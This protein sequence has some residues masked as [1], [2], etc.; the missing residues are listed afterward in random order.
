MHI[1]NLQIIDFIGV[2][3]F[4]LYVLS[5]GLLTFGV[6]SANCPRYYTLNLT[7]ASLV[8]VGL[9]WGNFNLAS[10][11]IQMFWIM[12]SLIGMI[13]RQPYRIRSN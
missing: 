1:S 9:V 8:L 5:Y 12:I 4:V 10:M 6:L 3:G 2:T 13:S 11:L 7:A